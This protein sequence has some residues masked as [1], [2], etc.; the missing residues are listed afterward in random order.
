M[1]K[2]KGAR[3][4]RLGNIDVPN[5][6]EDDENYLIEHNLDNKVVRIAAII[7]FQG[8]TEY[9]C[10]IDKPNVHK[11]LGWIRSEFHE[12]KE[13][14]SYIDVP[15]DLWSSREKMEKFFHPYSLAVFRHCYVQPL[16]KNKDAKIVL[17]TL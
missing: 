15:D 11:A 4:A 9:L 6:V 7:R 3:P 17:D 13:I 14:E 1:D 2:F 10:I 5:G 8:F 16:E 12:G